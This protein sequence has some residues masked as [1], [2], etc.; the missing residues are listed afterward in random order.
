[1]TNDIK[2]AQ[3][4]DTAAFAR[5]YETVYK[6]LYYTAYYALGN[7][8]HDAADAVSETVIDAFDSIKKLR[9]AE[10]FKSWIFSILSTKIK[11]KQKACYEYPENIEE[12]NLSENF[13]YSSAELKEAIYKLPKIDRTILSLS[14]LCGYRGEEIAKICGMNPSTVRSRLSRIKAALRLQLQD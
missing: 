10:S 1:M 7:N 3:Q 14:V 8:E 4:G 12:I 9:K 6:Q 2:L 5:L 13:S 11:Q